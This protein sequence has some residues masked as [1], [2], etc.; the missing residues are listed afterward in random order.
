MGR[1]RILFV[2]GRGTAIVQEF[3]SDESAEEA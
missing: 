2:D 3:N 1:T